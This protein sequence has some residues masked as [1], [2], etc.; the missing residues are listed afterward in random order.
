MGCP[1]R[2]Y[3]QALQELACKVCDSNKR[4]SIIETNDTDTLERIVSGLKDISEDKDF[5]FEAGVVFNSI[6]VRVSVSGGNDVTNACASGLIDFE[7]FIK[8]L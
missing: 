4:K 8:G 7:D 2:Y 6:F 5:Y 3:K 1:E